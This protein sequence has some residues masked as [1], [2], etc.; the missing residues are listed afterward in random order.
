VQ[1]LSALPEVFAKETDLQTALRL[2]TLIGN[3]SYD[4]EDG[5]ILIETLE[6]KRPNIGSL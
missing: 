5:W 2:A 3:L 4:S 1:A 6:F